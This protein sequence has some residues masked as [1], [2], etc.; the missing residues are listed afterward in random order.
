MKDNGTALIAFAYS[1]YDVSSFKLEVD[2]KLWLQFSRFH[3]I[4]TNPNYR[5]KI[6]VFQLTVKQRHTKKSQIHHPLFTPSST[7][8]RRMGIPMIT[9]TRNC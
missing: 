7:E 1:V 6:L 9:P 2:L 5:N 3:I 4:K 8:T